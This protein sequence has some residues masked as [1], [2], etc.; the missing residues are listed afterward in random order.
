MIVRGKN[1]G[2][3]ENSLHFD[4]NLVSSLGEKKGRKLVKIWFLCDNTSYFYCFY[5]Y[6]YCYWLCYIKGDMKQNYTKD[7]YMFMKLLV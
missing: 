6:C 3:L 4:I 2:K 1:D 5:C 7:I